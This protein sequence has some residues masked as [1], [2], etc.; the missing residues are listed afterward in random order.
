[1]GPQMMVRCKQLSGDDMVHVTRRPD[2]CRGES[3]HADHDGQPMCPSLT[4]RL[5]TTEF[6]RVSAREAMKQGK[7]PCEQCLG[8]VEVRQ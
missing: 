1:M 8:G 4:Q 3:F 7:T 2:R 6:E 5:H